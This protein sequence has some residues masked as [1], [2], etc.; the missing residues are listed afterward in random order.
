MPSKQIHKNKT[1]VQTTDTGTDS[2]TQP[3]SRDLGKRNDTKRFSPRPETVARYREAL[4]LYAQT[5]MTAK[6]ICEQC[7]VPTAGFRTYL[8]RFHRELL[9]A[10]YG[11]ERTSKQADRV[12]LK[13]KRGQTPTAHAKY[14]DAI[15]AC[16]DVKYLALNISQIARLFGLDGTGL[17]NQ[18]RRHYPDILV[19]REQERQ[20]R[21]LSDNQHRGM[22]PWCKEQ[23]APAVELL[24]TTEMTIP[25]AAEACHVTVSALRQHLLFYHHKLLD[26]RFEIRQKAKGVKRKGHVTGNGKRHEP[27]PE[28]QKRYLEAERLYRETPLTV[29]EIAERLGLKR[30]AL[31]FYLQTWCRES[32][33]ARRGAE[34]YEGAD[35]SETKH[36]LPSTAAKYAPAIERLKNS[37]LPTAKVAAEFGLH[38][39]CF[40]AYLREHYPE[41]YARQGMTRT[42]N[43]R[44]VSR[45]SMEKYAEA[46]HLYETTDEDLKSIA[47]RLG[48]VY[49]SLS[50]FIR[51]NFPELIARRNAMKMKDRTGD[52]PEQHEVQVK[53]KT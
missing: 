12:R 37:D 46:I 11:M 48:L 34:Y 42:E 31:S 41:L 22:R 9:L 17:A 6:Q 15:A 3:P 8:Q 25:E 44:L 19:R 51:R 40:R 10:R 53:N 24:Q 32:L 38:P 50:G 28:N 23:Y 52:T 30:S 33:F 7:G 36:Y 16:D 39:E 45:R 29:R 14:K 47:R 5:E 21:G 43:E 13:G 1:S 27:Q 18:L 20:R 35:L 4:E 2:A 26:K 49:N